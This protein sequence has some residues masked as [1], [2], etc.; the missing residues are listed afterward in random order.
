M[1][2]EFQFLDGPIKY[3]SSIS[4]MS[5]TLIEQ[6]K[7]VGAGIWEESVRCMYISI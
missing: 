5:A 2:I 1:V 7:C 4:T 3:S 6:M